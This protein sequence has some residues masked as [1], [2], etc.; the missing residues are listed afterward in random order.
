MSDRRT[1]VA[2]ELYAYGRLTGQSAGTAL[3]AADAVMSGYSMKPCTKQHDLLA[4]PKTWRVLR[5]ELSK[6]RLPALDAKR[7]K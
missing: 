4:G 5:S 2:G 3:A 1:E 6:T 7:A